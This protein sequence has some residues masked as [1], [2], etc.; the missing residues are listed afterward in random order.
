ME[1]SG[2]GEVRRIHIIYL[3]SRMGRVE[4]PHL[5]RVHHLNRNGVYL[6][7]V[8]RWM[9]DLRGKD[10]SE[11]FAWSYKRRYKNVFVWQ[12]LLDDDL[13]TP[14]SDNEYVLKGS[15]ILPLPS[16]D[17]EKK[18]SISKN[19]NQVGVEIEIEEK[20]ASHVS[21]DNS[22]DSST[23]TSSE[24][25]QESP[26]FGSGRSTLTEDSTNQQQSPSKHNFQREQLDNLGSYS[27][28]SSYSNLLSKTKHRN[29][30]KGHQGDDNNVNEKPGTPSPEF[31]LLY[32]YQESN[33]AK[34]KSNSN[35]ASKILRNLITC[36][37]VDT[38]DTALVSVNK[39]SL[40]RNVNNSAVCKRDILG[41]S[42]REFV[43][44]WNQ[45]KQQCTSARRSFDSV[46]GSN[47]NQKQ[48]SRFGNSKGVPAAYRPVGAPICS[49]CGKSF[50][51]EKLHT[52]MKS[53][54]GLKASAKTA[55][56]SVKKTP[57]S[58]TNF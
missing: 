56:D 7:D 50:R 8:K 18:A 33:Y 41:G 3:L 38:N 2:G 17:C 48:K 1:R 58:S 55:T 37:A 47:K 51:P 6:R 12:D 4:H 53:C 23:K 34:S 25:C 43:T 32:Q 14:I 16:D 15:Q 45:Q 57:P 40:S 29:G 39:S 54:K 26:I 52:H 44:N 5:I 49:Q 22:F 11:T 24:I 13:I 30:N 21:P 9:S 35:G 19:E 20:E 27:S 31:S 10:I 46:E 42:A 28:S 36:G